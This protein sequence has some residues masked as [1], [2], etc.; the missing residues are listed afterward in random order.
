MTKGKTLTNRKDY[1]CIDDNLKES[2]S[3]ERQA[4]KIN[5]LINKQSNEKENVHSRL[6][7]PTNCNTLNMQ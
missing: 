4:F 5:N 1:R 7:K 2:D 6:N 3:L